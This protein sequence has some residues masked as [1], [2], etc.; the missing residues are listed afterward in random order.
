MSAYFY[1]FKKRNIFCIP[2]SILVI[3]F[4]PW[5]LAATSFLISAQVEDSNTIKIN[6]N[7]PES[8]HGAELILYRSTAELTDP[9]INKVRYPVAEF[10]IDSGQNHATFLDRSAAHNVMYHYL[11]VILKKDQEEPGASSNIIEISLPD[12]AIEKLDDP[13]ILINKRYYFLEI[14][15]DGITTKRYPI[16][17]GRDPFK[18]KLHQDNKT[19]PEGIYRIINLQ[20][21]ATFYKA[22]DIDYPNTLDRI[23]YEFMKTEGLVP[24]GRGIGG[25]IQIHGQAPGWGSIQRNW[26]WGC[27]S[28][29]NSDID[30]IFNLPM[31][32]VGIPVFIF[33][34]DFALKDKIFLEEERSVDEIRSVQKKLE[35]IGLYMGMIDGVLGKQT[36][37]AIGRYQKEQGLPIS[38]V[39][40][41]R[42]VESLMDLP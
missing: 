18:R 16:S 37:F 29:R 21:R 8:L 9:N 11:A 3:L 20:A 34:Y 38:C 17:L 26:T 33:G 19:S 6:F 12:V 1:F 35:E 42:T 27:I 40:D 32:K 28:L 15:D 25:E 36:R 7:I 41:S 4:S 2:A 5:F 23:R 13:L 14:Q 30:E 39:L 10:L 22:I 24:N 31:L